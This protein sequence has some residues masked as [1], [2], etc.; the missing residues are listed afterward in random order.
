MPSTVIRAAF[1]RPDEQ[2]LDLTFVSGQR[3]RYFAVPPV[4][5]EGLAA[6][7]S[8]GAYFNT[9]IRDRF[10]CAEIDDADAG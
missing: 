10:A 5:A 1:Y 6:A 2:A 4:V 3:Y 7:R 9:R 8:K